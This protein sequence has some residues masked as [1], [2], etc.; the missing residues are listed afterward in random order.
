MRLH[1]ATLRTDGFV[2]VSSGY[3]GGRLVT[4]PLT[5]AGDELA[6]NFAPSVVGTLPVES[7]I[8]AAGRWKGTGSRTASRSSGDQTERV[9][10]WRGGTNASPLALHPIWLRFHMGKEV[11]L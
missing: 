5:F 10:L 3:A 9:V 1:R 8:S 6:V 11:D 4:R 2:S 7:R